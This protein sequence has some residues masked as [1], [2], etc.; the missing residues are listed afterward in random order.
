M[1]GKKVY[2]A[3]NDE[4]V[5]LTPLQEA[6]INK[7]TEDDEEEV[8]QLLAGYVDEHG[9]VHKEFTLREMTGK[10]EEAINKAD[11][12]GNG[13]KIA[14]ILLSRCVQRI[15]SITQRSAGAAKWLQI[16]KEIYSGDQDYMMLQLRRISIGD[17]I[18]YTNECPH[19][20][21]KLTTYLPVDEVGIVEF[22]GQRFI[23]FELPKGYK[24]KK[25]VLHTQ[26]IMRLATGLDREI[27]IPLAR[28]NPSK[29]ETTM[30]TRLCKFDDGLP[31]DD[32]I[33][34]SL[35]VRDRRYLQDILQDSLFGLETE[36]PVT[37]DTCG[38]SFTGSM[39]TSNFI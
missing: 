6:L 26:G 1:A 20:K 15:G 14:S 7:R 16:I 35:T 28:V 2:D 27:L 18:T 8:Y 12:R 30:L 29:A 37:C 11:L 9:T 34:S 23:P 33:M 21:A 19:C 24:D 36:I 17:E 25:G 13:P 10:D 32:D 39:N 22:K 3:T 4:E 38:E 31:V 5:E